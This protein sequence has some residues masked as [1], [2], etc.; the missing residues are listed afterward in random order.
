[1]G[2]STPLSAIARVWRTPVMMDPVQADR[3]CRETLS[4]A[5]AL[6]DDRFRPQII[7]SVVTRGADLSML[8]ALYRPSWVVGSHPS[9][10]TSDHRSGGNSTQY[11][12]N[13]S[14]GSSL[15]FLSIHGLSTMIPRDAVVSLA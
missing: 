1:M 3:I 6:D 15:Q 14:T 13:R 9:L 4:R 8:Q 10:I 7:P 5:V 11:W 12:G 2:E